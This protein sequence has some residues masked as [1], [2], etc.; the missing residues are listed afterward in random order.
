[1]RPEP[2]SVVFNPDGRTIA[3]ANLGTHTVRT[4]RLNADGPRPGR[5]GAS[6]AGRLS[7][8]VLYVV[9]EC[10]CDC[11]C[12]CVYSATG[13]IGKLLRRT[14]DGRRAMLPAPS[15]EVAVLPSGK[16]LYASNRATTASSAIAAAA[17]AHAFADRVDPEAMIFAPAPT[18]S[19]LL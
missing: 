10:D 3:A 2:Y 4:F 1:M 14:I 7:T 11:D 16:F 9:N 19:A 12:D 17:A 13:Q 18:A 8:R 6:S 5:H 15:A